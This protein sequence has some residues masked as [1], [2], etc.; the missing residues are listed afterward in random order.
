MG[1]ENKMEDFRCELQRWK[2]HFMF[3]ED[4]VA[5]IEKLLNSYVFEP[6]TPNLYE[7][8][9]QFKQKFMGSKQKKKQLEKKILAQERQLGGILECT[10]HM[11]D[12]NYGKK[13]D[14]L[15]NEVGQYFE[16]YQKIK[17]EVYGYAG[18]VLKRRK[19]VD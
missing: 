7:R 10:S 11:D 17:A 12:V 3:I 13:N 9:D 18:L 2:S 1:D 14:R 5:F 8:L 19:P 6:T 16:D 4:E 15:R